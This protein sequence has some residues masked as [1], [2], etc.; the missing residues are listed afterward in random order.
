V[1]VAALAV[2]PVELTK[3]IAAAAITVTVSFRMGPLIGSGLRAPVGY[4]QTP[5]QESGPI[6]ILLSTQPHPELDQLLIHADVS[7]GSNSEVAALPRD[8]CFTP[9]SRHPAGGLGCPVCANRRHRSLGCDDGGDY[10]ERPEPDRSK[11]IARSV[12]L[13]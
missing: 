5:A 7:F 9:E 4:P 11:V 13:F 8:V 1:A 2:Q 12:A 10:C 3:R 6:K